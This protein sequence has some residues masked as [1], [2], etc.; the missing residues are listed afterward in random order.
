MQEMQ[1]TWIQSLGQG[2]P[3]EEEM[4]THS[5]LLAWRIPWAEEPGGLQSMGL[6]RIRLDWVTEHTLLITN[7]GTYQNRARK[8]FVTHYLSNWW[9]NWGSNKWL[10]LSGD[11][12]AKT[13]HSMESIQRAVM[14][15]QRRQPG[16]WKVSEVGTWNSEGWGLALLCDD[17]SV[18]LA[19]FT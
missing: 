8:V 19:L 16:T 15:R 7:Y 13:A 14:P 12:L 1:E 6:Q 10:W 4:A 3:L 17:E 9:R 18:T 11:L 2:D 5:S